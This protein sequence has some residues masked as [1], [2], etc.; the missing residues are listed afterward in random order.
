MSQY[1]P[2]DG[3]RR[4]FAANDV[5][6]DRETALAEM[7]HSARMAGIAGTFL[8]RLHPTYTEAQP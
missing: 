5:A 7:D 3:V 1:D 8:S 4:E 2:A 6:A